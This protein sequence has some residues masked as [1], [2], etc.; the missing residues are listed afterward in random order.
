MEVGR[1]L[2]HIKA[3]YRGRVLSVQDL[4]G[5]IALVTMTNG[6]QFE[7]TVTDGELKCC[8]VEQYTTC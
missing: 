3:N 1:I 2:S 7:V 5:G 6:R 8:P 4:G